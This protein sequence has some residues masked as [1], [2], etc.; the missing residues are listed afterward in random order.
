MKYYFAPMEGITGPIHRKAFDA[1]FPGV[2]KYFT[3]FIAPN[4]KGKFSARE[5]K[6]ID[7]EN[8]RGIF[9]VPQIMTNDAGI[10]R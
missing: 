9:L 2:D 5:K 6:D 1:C 3:A 10:L 4:Q 8:N 7:P